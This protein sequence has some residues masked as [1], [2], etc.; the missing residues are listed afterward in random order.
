MASGEKRGVRQTPK[1]RRTQVH[2]GGGGS[3]L[4]PR[5]SCGCHAVVRKPWVEA[6]QVSK[7]RNPPESLP[8]DFPGRGTRAL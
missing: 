7:A 5:G 8:Q 2:Q 6:G 3:Q 1:P 4:R